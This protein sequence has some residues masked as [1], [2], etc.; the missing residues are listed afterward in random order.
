MRKL[1]CFLVLLAGF[2]SSAAQESTVRLGYCDGKFDGSNPMGYYDYYPNVWKSAAICLPQSMLSQYAGMRIDSIHVGL[3]SKVNIDQL[4]VWVRTD[5][6]GEDI[7]SG[8]F[9]FTSTDSLVK[10]WNTVKLDVPCS[11]TGEETLYVGYSFHQAGFC[12]G[13]SKF[14]QGKENAFFFKRDDNSAWSDESENGTLVLEAF[15]N[16]GKVLVRDLALLSVAQEGTYA[17]SADELKL[18]LNVKNYAKTTITG[19]DATCTIEGVDGSFTQHFDTQLAMRETKNFEWTINPGI[20]TTE[21]NK[22]EMTVTITSLNEGEDENM[23]NNTATASMFVGERNTIRNVVL[24]EFTTERCSNC[25]PVANAVHEILAKDKYKNRVF[26]V[27]HHVGYYTDWLTSSFDKDYEWFYNGQL[28]APA[29]MVD[30]IVGFDPSTTNTPV[31]FPS[32]EEMIEEVLDQQ[33]DQPVDASLD[34]TV[35]YAAETKTLN[36]HVDGEKYKDAITNNPA[37]ITVYL[38]E[39][40]I[41]NQSQAGATSTFLHHGVNRKV[42]SS[43]GDVIEWYGNNFSYDCQLAIDDEYK[44]ENLSVVAF[45]GEYNSS[46]QIDCK[47]VNSARVMSSEFKSSTVIDTNT[48]AGEPVVE[49]YYNLRGQ[50]LAQPEKGV[51][52]VKYSNGTTRKMIIR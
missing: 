14:N 40:N 30:R 41:N 15:A 48:V 26:Q 17:P 20:T 50:R 36:I 16:S 8:T 6:D 42:N 52:I 47:I 3:A 27:S 51:N 39:N 46:S 12:T 13:I 32:S 7:A 33:L 35:S 9:Q 24:E 4:K 22:R 29:L 10:G 19:F 21:P 44:Y 34:M 38:V 5:L 49:G 11:I 1:L 18:N 37:R 28:Y 43:F 45:I 31:F 2:L 23:G 25:P